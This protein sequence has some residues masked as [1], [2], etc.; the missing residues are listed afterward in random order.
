MSLRLRLIVDRKDSSVCAALFVGIRMGRL[1]LGVELAGRLGDVIA[2]F[3][4][5]HWR[6]H[7]LG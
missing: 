3:V 7:L 2:V 1:K 5:C 4:Q 6:L